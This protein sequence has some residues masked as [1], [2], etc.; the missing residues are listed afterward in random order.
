MHPNAVGSPA[1]RPR[2]I[3]AEALAGT[4]RRSAGR[5]RWECTGPGQRGEGILRQNCSE[6]ADVQ[7]VV[8]LVAPSSTPAA[9]KSEIKKLLQA[10]N[11]RRTIAEG[12]ISRIF[13]SH[14]ENAEV[15]T[16]ALMTNSDLL[17]TSD[18]TGD[19]PDI[20]HVG[21]K[22]SEKVFLSSS[23]VASG[24]DL[25]EEFAR[26]SPYFEVGTLDSFHAD[27]IGKGDGA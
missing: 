17:S 27:A 21:L 11:I 9:A 18:Q 16:E 2:R 23:K 14:A 26:M 4:S 15:E 20:V 25:E 22:K 1:K 3:T 12:I 5:W 10:R 13:S 6:A 24:K 19:P 7:T 8:A